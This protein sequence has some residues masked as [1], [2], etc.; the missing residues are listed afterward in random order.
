V[1]RHLGIATSTLRSWHQ[2]YSIG[3]HDSQPGR[4]RRYSAADVAQLQRMT[5]LIKLGMLASE[6]AGAVQDGETTAVPAERDAADLI[7]AARAADTERCRAL[8]D[9]VMDRRGVVQ[10][11]EEVCRP[12]L[13]A[14]DADQRDAPDCMDMEHALS[15]AMLGALHRVPRPPPAP[16]AGLVLLACVESE[17][18]TLPLAALAAALAS[19]R[20][21]VRMLGASTPAQSLVRAVRDTAPSAAVLW[22]Q[23]SET[24]RP[25]V[26]RAL[27]PYGVLLFA[28]GPGWPPAGL[29]GTGH[30]TGLADALTVIAGPVASWPAR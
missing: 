18:H 5:E 24:G 25:P 13:I 29:D 19:R 17:Q 20:V 1:A 30:L 26:L 6:A 12:A 2:R 22:S 7:A 4:Y 10:A 15:W 11:W 21:P 16:G 28:A 9:H 8:L 27:R 3:P 23:R 14:V